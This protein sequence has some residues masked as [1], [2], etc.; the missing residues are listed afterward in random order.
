MIM[1]AFYTV[2]TAL[3][4]CFGVRSFAQ[5]GGIDIA[6][7]QPASSS[8]FT[9]SPNLAF[10]GDTSTTEWTA[11]TFLGAQY[12]YVDLGT[13]TSLCAVNLYWDAN[14]FAKGFTVDIA[15]NPN[16]NSW[17]NVY[18]ATVNAATINR[19]NVVGTAR[20]VR[21]RATVPN[22]G[23]AFYGLYEMEV[24]GTSGCSAVDMAKGKTATSSGSQSGFPPGNATDGNLL[25]PWWSTSNGHH[26][27]PENL[28]VN[29]GSVQAICNVGVTFS[30]ADYATSYTIDL[31]SN[32]TTF[33]TVST[34]TGNTSTVNVLSVTGSGQYVRFSGI[35]NAA[36]NG[37]NIPELSVSGPITSLPI[38]LVDFTATNENNKQVL[39]QW[40]TETEINNKQF[41]I[42]RST[43]GI[44]FTTIGE[45]AGAGN[46]VTA[47]SYQWTDFSPENGRDLY[48]LQQVDLDGVLS[49]SPVDV[50][51]IGGTLGNSLSVFPNPAKDLVNI[52]N[53]MGELLREVRVYTIGGVEML[54][55][56]PSTTGSVQLSV[57]NWPGGI[58]LI[59]IITEKGTEVLKLLK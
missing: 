10:D 53:P 41:N 2:L 38:K 32:G 40:T 25:T 8:S 6:L 55:L 29:L 39:L 47:L 42:Q 35:S 52:L 26:N 48:R 50:V 59:K 22:A 4:L 23:A 56:A 57:G 33:N 44:N 20:Y 46:S 7:N 27:D 5:C 31:S 37:Y 1:R 34:V 49:Y 11:P 36:G 21:M 17:V 13:A 16:N 9:G 43:D 51:S 58:Y 28:V 45:V 18:T 24:F 3:L 14:N 19:L 54:R 12:L 15:N 30:T